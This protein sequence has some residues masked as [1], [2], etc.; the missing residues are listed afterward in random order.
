MERITLADI[1]WILFGIGIYLFLTSP[2]PLLIVRW[3]RARVGRKSV[4]PLARRMARQSSRAALPISPRRLMSR[5][6]ARTDIPIGANPKAGVHAEIPLLNGAEP[7]AEPFV[8]RSD[9]ALNA[10]EIAAVARM[11][12]H[13]RTA[14]KPSKSSTIQS[15]FG[16]S[17]GGSAA[18]T[19]ASAIYDALFGPPAPAV[20]YR[21]L[22]PEQEAMRAQL[23]LKQ[24][25]ALN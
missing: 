18:Y 9:L 25:G 12:E 19:R 17:R 24:K 21:P 20:Q 8:N 6:Y 16:V 1:G 14:A 13:N 4:A 23:R 3:V 22:T 5:R 2:A 11:I 7:Q 10:V 15:G